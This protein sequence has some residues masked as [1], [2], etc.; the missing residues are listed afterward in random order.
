MLCG[1]SATRKCYYV[2][3]FSLFLPNRMLQMK[4]S[5]RDKDK[6]L[7]IGTWVLKKRKRKNMKKIN[8]PTKNCETL[9]SVREMYRERDRKGKKAEE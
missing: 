3:T 2:A 5:F 4:R 9:S 8:R 7:L 1:H 6:L